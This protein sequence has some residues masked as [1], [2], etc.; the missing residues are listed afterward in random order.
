[1]FYFRP[2]VMAAIAALALGGCATSRVDQ[3]H[4]RA[5]EV[6]AELMS[7]QRKALALSATE[8]SQRLDH[9]SSLRATLSAANVGLGAVPHLVEPGKRDIAYDV[10]EEVYD[11]I[12]WNIPL[13][14]GDMLRP[15]PSEFSGGTLN[16]DN[17]RRGGPGIAR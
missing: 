9:L 1:M 5:D 2:W 15:L 7:E 13:G 8:R 17:V 12:E 6:K 11:T 4:R 3:L 14:P 16:L 10:L